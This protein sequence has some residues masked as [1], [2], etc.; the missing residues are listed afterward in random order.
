MGTHHC[1]HTRSVFQV[2]YHRR[3]GG[4]KPQRVVH[5][6]VSQVKEK[7]VLTVECLVLQ[8]N[9]YENKNRKKNWTNK[10]TE[11]KKLARQKNNVL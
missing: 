5:G 2:L 9:K 3:T 8:T 7:R 11:K 6:L 4:G 10:K 1:V